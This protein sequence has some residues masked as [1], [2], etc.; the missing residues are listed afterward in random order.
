[1]L[2]GTKKN[3]RE[4]IQM[5]IKKKKGKKKEAKEKTHIS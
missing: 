4:S 5:S 1:M 3:K 2:K